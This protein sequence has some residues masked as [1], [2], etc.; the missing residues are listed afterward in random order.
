LVNFGVQ[1]V[2]INDGDRI[3]QLVVLNITRA[4]FEEVAELDETVRSDGGFGSTG[5]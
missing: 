4:D 1:P 5:K 2:T 3:A